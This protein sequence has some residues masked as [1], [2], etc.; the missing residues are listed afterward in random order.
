MY[1]LIN[2]QL[3]VNLQLYNREN[4]LQL[5]FSAPLRNYYTE[6]LIVD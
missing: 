3:I 6:V 5:H 4:K 1:I 2:D